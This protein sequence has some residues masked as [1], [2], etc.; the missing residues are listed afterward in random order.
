MPI[1]KD[2][3]DQPTAY[4]NINTPDHANVNEDTED[5]HYIPDENQ[6][7]S[8]EEEEQILCHRKK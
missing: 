4:I 5:R 7:D 8:V 3:S 1:Y 2:D 6:N